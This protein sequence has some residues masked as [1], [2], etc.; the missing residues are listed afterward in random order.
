MTEYRDHIPSMTAGRATLVGLMQRYLG[1][2]FDPSITL[3]EVHKLMYFMQVAGEPLRLKYAK[4]QYGPYAE[5]L[6]HVLNKIEGHMVF[7][8]ADGGDR[9][10]KPLK[11]VPGAVEEAELFL[12]KHE[13]SPRTCEQVVKSIYAWDDHKRQFTPRQIGIAIDVLTQQGWVAPLQ[14]DT[15]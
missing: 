1:G 2:L 7:G 10:D 15:I 9:P 14:G 4:G 8:Y 13:D 12:R 3:L 6:R 5:N 11:L